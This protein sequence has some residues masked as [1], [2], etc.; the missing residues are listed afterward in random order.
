M[1][2]RGAQRKANFFKG[3]MRDPDA[4]TA[5]DAAIDDALIV[6]AASID[7]QAKADGHDLST[8]QRQRALSVAQRLLRALPRDQL[9]NISAHSGLLKSITDQSLAVAPITDPR[10]AAQAR[11]EE[12]GQGVGTG[13][14]ATALI[15]RR[16]LD[17]MGTSSFARLAELG[18]ATSTEMARTIEQARYEA[19]RL[20]MPWAA[21]NPE[22]LKLGP[23][24][25][26]T[27]HDAG[28]QKERFERMTGDKV[29]FRASTAVAIAAY[30]K[31]HNLTPEQTNALYDK[32]NN[33]VEIISGGDKAIQRELDEATRKFVSGPDTPEARKAL[34]ESYKKHATTP[35]AQRAAEDVTKALV[36]PTQREAA[37]IVKATATE[38]LEDDLYAQAAAAPDPK[39]QPPKKADAGPAA[40]TEGGATKTA[41]V[42]AKPAAPKV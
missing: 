18:G 31:K 37:A 29:G 1:Q 6:V 8:V 25:I 5:P 23:G 41:V 19:F 14:P 36:A 28:V 2:D 3:T 17:G 13:D 42:A 27:L 26:K 35:E 40:A 16:G 30:A 4:H 10:A 39:T 38:K 11:L 21:N 12:R 15:G 24:A 20:G 32:I 9:Q 22:L 34:E 7:A 33:G